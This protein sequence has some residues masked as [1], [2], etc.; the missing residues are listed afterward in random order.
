MPVRTLLLAEDDPHI[1]RVVEVTLR[2]QG[3]EVTAVEDGAQALQ[4]LETRLFDLIVVDG[5]MPNVDGLE[6]CRRV[7]ADV[8]TA[9]IPIVMLSARTSLTDENE[10]RAAGACAFIRKPF[11]AQTLGDELR[12]ACGEVA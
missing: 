7:K 4:T 10:V 12:R 2:R 3:F 6:V 9:S 8:R 5:M 11:N 1:R